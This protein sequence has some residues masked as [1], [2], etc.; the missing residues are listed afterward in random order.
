MRG[1]YISARSETPPTGPSPLPAPKAATPR[2]RANRQFPTPL[3]PPRRP[4]QGPIQYPAQRWSSSTS[5]TV[6]NSGWR[7]PGSSARTGTGTHRWPRTAGCFCPHREAAVDMLRSPQP[8][9]P[10]RARRT[11]RPSPPRA[12]RKPASGPGTSR[13]LR[14][15]LKER[16]SGTHRLFAVQR[17]LDHSTS[18]GPAT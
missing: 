14:R 4:C 8:G 5:R 6:S 10:T 3:W 13:N 7:D 15:S 1:S 18:T 2:G 16:Q 11:L 12:R 9:R 17:Y